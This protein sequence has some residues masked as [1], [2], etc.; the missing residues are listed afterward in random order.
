MYSYVTMASLLLH[1]GG[2]A[3]AT[4]CVIGFSWRVLLVK[5]RTPKGIYL[6]LHPLLSTE[7]V[8]S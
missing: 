1:M 5:E 3:D 4:P 7:I 8:T 6:L 2:M